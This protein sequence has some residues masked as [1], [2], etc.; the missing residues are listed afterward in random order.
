MT[1]YASHTDR[2]W[3]DRD[4]VCPHGDDPY[5]CDRGACDEF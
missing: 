3:W 5:Y 2:P 4:R 1:R